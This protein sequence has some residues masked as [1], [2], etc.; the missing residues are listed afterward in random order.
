M[1]DG[2]LIIFAKAPVPGHTK[3]RLIPHLG[4]EGAVD[5]HRRLVLYTLD[6][7]ARSRFDV[8]QLWC[9]PS[10]DHPFFQDCM[11]NFDITLHT[12]QGVDLGERMAYALNSALRHSRYVVLIGTDCPTLTIDTLHRAGDL[13]YRGMDVVVAPATDGGYV[14]LGSCRFSSKLFSSI[15]WGTDTV[16]QATRNRLE[17]LGWLWRELAEHRDIDR[18]Q[19]LQQLSTNHVFQHLFEEIS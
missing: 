4:A 1:S 2:T 15:A 12:Q 16:M 14:L 11:R 7:A 19:D 13:L 8:T 3:T 9:T 18:P 17:K 5:L 10:Q 6:T